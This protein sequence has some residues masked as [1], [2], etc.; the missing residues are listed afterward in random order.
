MKIHKRWL[1][2]A[3]LFIA[4]SAGAET[5]NVSGVKFDDT[6]DRH[7]AIGNETLAFATATGETGE[8]QQQ[9]EFDVLAFEAEFMKRHGGRLSD[10][11]ACH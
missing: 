5:M 1:L 2:A 6:V 7:Q 11:R 10:D 4:C 8:L 3:A 9:I